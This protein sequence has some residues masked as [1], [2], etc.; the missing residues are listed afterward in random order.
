[1]AVGAV[2]YY[3]TSPIFAEEPPLQVA[4]GSQYKTQDTAVS[5]TI[6]SLEAAKK[7]KARPTPVP[8]EAK[9]TSPDETSIGASAET[10][11]SPVG[12]EQPPAP[13]AGDV[14]QEGQGGQEA[15][16]NPETGEINWD[17]PC[18]GGMAHGPCGEDFRAAFSCFVYSQEEPKGMDCIDKFKAMQD[19]FRQHPDIYGNEIDDDEVDAQLDEHIASEK[20][21]EQKV[22]SETSDA[23]PAAVPEPSQ[24]ESTPGKDTLQ[25][26]V[27]KELE[28]IQSKAS[29]E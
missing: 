6:E 9:T 28:A 19:C 7:P 8:S 15:A 22:P 3:N 27:S 1:M 2:Y 24:P 25:D 21:A 10:G 26:A 13:A 14:E 4:P 29:K 17:C 20:Q 23:A 12:G 16:F 5:Q 11:A 18:L